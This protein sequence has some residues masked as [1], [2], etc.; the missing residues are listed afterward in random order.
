MDLV[1]AWESCAFS[2]GQICGLENAVLFL[3]DDGSSS[4][5]KAYTWAISR[6]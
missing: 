4:Y 6:R 3:D 1:K 2:D 5:P